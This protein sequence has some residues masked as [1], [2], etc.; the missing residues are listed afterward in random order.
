MFEQALSN[1]PSYSG[2]SDFYTMKIEPSEFPIQETFRSVADGIMASDYFNAGNF[3]HFGIDS[4]EDCLQVVP[5]VS[6]VIMCRFRDGELEKTL[7]QCSEQP[8]CRYIIVQTLIGDDGYVSPDTLK[9]LPDNIVRIYSKNVQYQHDRLVP[10][11]IGRDWRVTEEAFSAEFSRPPGKPP[12]CHTYMNFSLET[13][14]SREK[15]YELLG[16][17]PWVTASKPTAYRLYHKSH[18]Q[19]V[20]E[21]ADHRFTLS[22]IGKAV[23]CYRTWDALFARSIPVLDKTAHSPLYQDLPA[24]IVSDWSQ[25]NKAFLDQAYAQLRQQQFNLRKLTVGYWKQLIQADAQ[26]NF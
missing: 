3:R 24:I 23:D 11:P 4:L 1:G 8:T 12:E 22:P 18:S 17:E 25:V 6:S 26:A 2:L 16:N 14:P 20:T 15:L 7:L 9:A 10:I 21:M 19:Y 5:K 13:H